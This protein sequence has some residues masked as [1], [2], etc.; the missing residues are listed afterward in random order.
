MG[1]MKHAL[2]ATGTSMRF[3][4]TIRTGNAGGT[5]LPRI[6]AP[7]P[8]FAARWTYRPWLI[9]GKILDQGISFDIR[10]HLDPQM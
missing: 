5:M 1:L 10:S 8:Q 9:D 6:V 3:C 4:R 2:S 7:I